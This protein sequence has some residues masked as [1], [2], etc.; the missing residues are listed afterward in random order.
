MSLLLAARMTLSPPLLLLRRRLA[1]CRGTLLRRGGAAGI[2][3]GAGCRLAAE[4]PVAVPAAPDCGSPCAGVVPSGCAL[5]LRRRTAVCACG[6]LAAALAA[7]PAPGCRPGARC[8]PAGPC[9]RLAAADSW[10]AR[11]RPGCAAPP[12]PPAVRGLAAAAAARP[13]GP[14]CP[15]AAA[16]TVVLAGLAV[17]PL[18]LPAWRRSFGRNCCCCGGWSGRGMRLSAPDWRGG[19][20]AAR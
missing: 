10:P 3:L 15:A 18:R 11:W 2:R 17:R 9:P 12:C 20:R 19:S 6:A 13:G 5:R 8:A 16:R 7:R 14:A 4:P 1:R